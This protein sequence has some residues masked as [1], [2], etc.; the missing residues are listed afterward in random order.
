VAVPAT[1][2]IEGLLGRALSGLLVIGD[3]L[4]LQAAIM[5][6]AAIRAFPAHWGLLGLPR[7]DA[8]GGGEVVE[9]A[10]NRTRGLLGLEM[11]TQIGNNIR[12]VAYK[13]HGKG[14]LFLA[15]VGVAS[16]VEKLTILSPLKGG[17]GGWGHDTPESG[18]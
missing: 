3:A 1:L 5:A 12:G 7:L 11:G 15:D 8:V 18:S 2:Q 9:V 14:T 16:H 17:G 13:F 4:T 6:E 10:A